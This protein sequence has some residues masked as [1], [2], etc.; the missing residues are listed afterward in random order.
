MRRKK[1]GKKVVGTFCS[2]T[3]TEPIHAAG[4][5]PV[6]LCGKF[7]QGGGRFV[8]VGFGRRWIRPREILVGCGCVCREHRMTGPAAPPFAGAVSLTQLFRRILAMC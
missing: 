4:A 3:P 1:K 2:H 8:E 6:G 7:G 5:I